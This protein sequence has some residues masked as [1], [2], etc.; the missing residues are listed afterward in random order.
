MT[1][2]NGLAQGLWIAGN[3]ISGD[4]GSIDNANGGNS[5]LVVTGIDKSGVER[6]GGLRDGN[7]EYTAFFNPA[8]G[9]VHGVL[10]QTLFTGLVDWNATWIL[11]STAGEEAFSIVAK[12]LDYAPTR[13]S[14]GSL[15]FKVQMPANGFGAEWGNLLTAGKRVDTGATSPATGVDFTDVST[16]FG[17]QAWLHVFA[18]TGT[19]VVVTI[20]DSADNSSFAN[21]AGGAFT[22][23]TATPGSQRLE[24]GRT[25]TVR[26]YLKVNTT[27]VF[28]SATIGVSFT[29]NLTA[30]AF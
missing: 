12:E 27:G 7:L 5:P 1:K 23:V 29:R 13:G 30:V 14:D 15:T 16:A 21:L 9:G 2:R 20:Q 17:W 18:L 10:K 22:S 11:G 6:I 25:A 26:R 28:T 24:G 3:D 8:A 4:V 19:N